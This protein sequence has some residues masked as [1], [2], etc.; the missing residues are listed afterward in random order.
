MFIYIHLPFCLSHCIYC[1]FYV[2]LKATEDRRQAYLNALKQ[3]IAHYLGQATHCSP[4]RTIYLGGGTPALFPAE[5]IASL[6]SLLQSFA[7][8]APDAEITLEANPE[9]MASLPSDY[10]QTGVNRLSIGVQSLQPNELKRLSRVHS[11]D[12]VFRFLDQVRT[13]GFQNISI[14]LMYGIPEQTMETWQDTLSQAVQLPIEHISMYGLKVE[15]DTALDTLIRQGRMALPMDEDTVDMYEFAVNYLAQQGFQ[16]Y[17][18]SNLSKP[19]FESRHNL[20][21][22]DNNEFWGFGVS[23]HG[24]INQVRYENARNLQHY[25]TNPILRV[26]NHFC[27]P[28]EQ[29]ENALIFGLRKRAGVSIVELERRYSVDFEKQYLPRIQRYLDTGYLHLE[30]GFLKLDPKAIPVS[31]DILSAFMD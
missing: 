4:I 2:E 25:Q 10:R 22:W 18:I 27:T 31:N 21:Y 17:E 11:R 12:Q 19:G 26:E 15:E 7:P 23:A 8:F 9:G 6:L 28:Q 13:A 29:L 24:Y 20:N 5:E 1:D 14:D 30:D 16:L 3:E